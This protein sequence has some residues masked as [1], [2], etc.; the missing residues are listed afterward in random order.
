V[1]ISVFG[2][3]GKTRKKLLSL[4]KDLMDLFK[5]KVDRWRPTFFK[6]ARYYLYENLRSEILF[7]EPSMDDL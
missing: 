7:P 4:L 6:L 2:K 5:W 3:R 1:N